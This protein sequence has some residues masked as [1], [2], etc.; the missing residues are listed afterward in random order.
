T[1]DNNGIGAIAFSPLEQGI[2]TDKYLK[3]FPEG[4][5]AVKDGRYLNPDQISK[6]VLLKVEKLNDIAKSR[7]QNMAQMAIAWLLKDKRIT[8]VLVGASSSKQLL[9]SV[10]AL[11]NLGFSKDEL[12]QI[13]QILN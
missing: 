3:G 5:R 7:D 10:K 12:K 9:D 8:S 6:E 2:L 1:L 4:S 13:D 11:D